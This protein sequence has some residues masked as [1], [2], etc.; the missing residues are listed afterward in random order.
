M[1]RVDVQGTAITIYSENDADPISP[2]DMLEAKGGGFSSNNGA[3]ATVLDGLSQMP[4][5][6]PDSCA[7]Y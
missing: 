6:Y 5:C 3:N 7:R 2:T 4:Q 1:A